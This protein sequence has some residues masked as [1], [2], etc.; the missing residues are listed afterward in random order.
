M[1]LI[2]FVFSVP[3]IIGV[4]ILHWLVGFGVTT[5]CASF[6][7][8]HQIRSTLAGIAPEDTLSRFLPVSG[9]TNLYAVFL[10]LLV[11]LVVYGFAYI[12][13]KL[14]EYDAILRSL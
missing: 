5:A 10:S 1:A 9:K 7:A 2:N 14:P 3:A 6:F 12:A 4:D 13:H 8:T 11:V